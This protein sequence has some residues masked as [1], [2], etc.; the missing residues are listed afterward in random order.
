[1][2]V[3]GNQAAYTY[4]EFQSHA[5]VGHWFIR[6]VAYVEGLRAFFRQLFGMAGVIWNSRCGGRGGLGKM[7]G[8]GWFGHISKVDS[9]D[10]IGP[11]WRRGIDGASE[12]EWR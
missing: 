12:W 9:K 6:K 1:V 8:G 11:L 10:C 3:R 2:P 5:R 7:G 4:K